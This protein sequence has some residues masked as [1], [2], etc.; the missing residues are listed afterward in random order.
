M[1]KIQDM[2][3]WWNW[4]QVKELTVRES[5]NLI[6]AYNRRH[7]YADIYDAYKK[8]SETKV[9]VWNEW[10]SW[11]KEVNMFGYPYA[12]ENLSIC[13][14]TCQ[15]F[16]VLATIREFDRDELGNYLTVATYIMVATKSRN[17]LCRLAGDENG[18]DIDVC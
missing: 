2:E 15:T 3:I 18:E 10:V 16:S 17:Y 13:D 5:A 8:P 4:F 14:T 6:D 12:V 1:K 11:A 9:S 7:K